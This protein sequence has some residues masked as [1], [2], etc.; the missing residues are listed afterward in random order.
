M[1]WVVSNFMNK[2]PKLI[3]GLLTLVVIVYLLNVGFVQIGIGNSPTPVISNGKIGRILNCENPDEK[4]MLRCSSLS[5]KKWL[6]D[7]GKANN[8]SEI[9][10]NQHSYKF[11]DEPKRYEHIAKISTTNSVY[12]LKCIMNE[13]EMVKIEWVD[14]E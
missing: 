5:C 10:I 8:H 2:I 14:P 11:S 7:N 4:E 6:L 3:F 1:S 12:Y 9:E 13:L